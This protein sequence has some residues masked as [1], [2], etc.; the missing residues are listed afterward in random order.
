MQQQI[1]LY[2]PIDSVKEEPFTAT[3]MLTILALTLVLM[4]AFYGVLYSKKAGLEAEI[5]TLK[6]QNEQT[7]I[8]VQKLEATVNKLTDAKKEQQQL[9]YLKKIYASK[10]NALN[11]LSTMAKGNSV[12]VSGY[13][14]ALA[15][16]D[17]EPIWFSDIDVYSGGQQV[18]L[19]GRATDARAIPQFV[20]LLK[21]EPV[22]NGVSFRVFNAQRNDTDTTLDFVL[23]TELPEQT[24]TH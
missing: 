7:L 22:F 10:Q 19:K 2:Q 4:L 14:S 8:V 5:K 15:R 13:F 3:M 20:A 1:N 16:K 6:Q 11:E 9:D 23:K 17:I 24:G 12:G 21:Q 18:L